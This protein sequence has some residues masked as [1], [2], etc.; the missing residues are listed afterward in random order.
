[1]GYTVRTRKEIHKFYAREI[2][3]DL[4]SLEE[5]RLKLRG[6]VKRFFRLLLISCIVL[7]FILLP[8]SDSWLDSLKMSAGINI[9]VFAAI[10]G[11]SNSINLYQ[12]KVRYLVEGRLIK[13]LVPDFRY[14]PN[15][16]IP[17]GTFLRSQLFLHKPKVYNGRNKVTGKIG[18]TRVT[19]SEVESVEQG[20]EDKIPRFAGIFL[21]AE[22][23]K[24]FKTRTIV[25]PDLACTLLGPAG[26]TVQSMNIYRPPLVKLEDPEFE[27]YFAV[28]ADDQI[29]ARYILSP[30]LME[31]ILTYRKKYDRHV[32]LSFIGQRL[33][34][35][36][37][38]SWYPLFQPSI[39][40]SLFEYEQI[41]EY[42][43]ILQMALSTVDELNLN[44]RIWSKQ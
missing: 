29:E 12:N 15:G 36:V 14:E 33:F 11:C 41:E 35:A 3:P 21:V 27:D 30:A 28:Y 40:V 26:Q 43:E 13:F 19:L 7:F 23:N 17:L 39:A 2:L 44:T 8:I 42:C 34:M 18:E 4:K 1:M 9:I 20:S 37:R 22:F 5:K 31:R 24:T 6:S 16:S 25:V 32:Y 10:A 38:T